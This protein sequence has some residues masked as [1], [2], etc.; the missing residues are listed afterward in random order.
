MDVIICEN[1]GFMMQ[2]EKRTLDWVMLTAIVSPFL[3]IST[4]SVIVAGEYA[5]SKSAH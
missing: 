2:Y 3:K 4:I 5:A 1:I